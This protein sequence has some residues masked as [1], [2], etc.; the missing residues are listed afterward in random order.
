M[1][2]PP[3]IWVTSIAI[4]SAAAG[5]WLTSFHSLS[6]KLVPFGGGALLGHIDEVISGA[7]GLPVVVAENALICVARGAGL[8]LE[9]PAYKGVL[10]PA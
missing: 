9:D 4:V 1:S 5:I 8:A 6:R 10:T 2:L 7:T 3:A